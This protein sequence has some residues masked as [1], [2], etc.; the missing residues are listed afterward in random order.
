MV[1]AGCG[2]AFLRKVNDE[3]NARKVLRTR[4]PYR[5]ALLAGLSLLPA[6]AEESEKVQRVVIT[7]SNISRIDLEGRHQWK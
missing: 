4:S 5:F 7:G 2:R 6:Q 3:I 1:I